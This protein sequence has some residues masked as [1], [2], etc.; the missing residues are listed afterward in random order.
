MSEFMRIKNSAHI[1][2][3]EDAIA[4]KAERKTMQQIAQ[5][6]VKN[7]PNTLDNLRKKK[8]DE[9]I[10][11]A[12]DEEIKRRE[13]DAKEAAFQHDLRK[14]AVE[15]S[16]QALFL[17][18]DQVKALHSKMLLAD[19]LQERDAQVQLQKRK[20]AI[21]KEIDDEY[22]DLEKQKMNDYDEKE[23]EKDEKKKEKKH[24]NADTIKSQWLS[25]IHI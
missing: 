16:N 11:K 15:R 1:D 12:M 3:A 22:A 8:E 23:R 7:W 24:L 17:Q 18:Q 20:K 5:S 6:K 10:K 9:K 13:I 19:A 4:R 25:L 21:L 2:T 14:T